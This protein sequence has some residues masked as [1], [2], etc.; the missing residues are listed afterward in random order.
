MMKLNIGCGRNILDGWI[1][2]DRWPAPGVDVAANLDSDFVRL[3]GIADNCVDEFLLSHVIEHIHKPLPLMQTLHCL[4]KPGAIATIRTPYG[5][6]DD[7]WEDQTHVRPYF[8]GSF[9]YFSQPFYWRADYAYRGDWR[10][11]KIVLF[12][13]D[14]IV[15]L[16]MIN[17]FRNVV[18]EMVVELEAVKPIR[19]PNKA[20]Q[21]VPVIELAVS[22]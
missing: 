11:K 2:V 16:N 17:A 19:E 4:A 7:A 5:S 21:D 14:A 3:S 12:V 8:L 10:V 22:A 1:N 15:N 6:S 13:P 9:G 20:L 18:K